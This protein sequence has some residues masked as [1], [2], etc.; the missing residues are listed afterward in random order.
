MPPTLK[1]G[2]IEFPQVIELALFQNGSADKSVRR[3]WCVTA[4]I[5]LV[6]GPKS[7]AAA[8]TGSQL[9]VA[10]QILKSTKA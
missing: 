4:R 6:S 3:T 7:T 1:E 8:T 5:L 2:Q 10:A 9:E